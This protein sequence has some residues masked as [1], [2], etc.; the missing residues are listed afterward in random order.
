MDQEL[1]LIFETF[2]CYTFATQNEK[3]RLQNTT[4]HLY[5]KTNNNKSNNKQKAKQNKTIS[6]T[7]KAGDDLKKRAVETLNLDPNILI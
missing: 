1:T 3:T 6:H 4:T 7:F 5:K 2:S